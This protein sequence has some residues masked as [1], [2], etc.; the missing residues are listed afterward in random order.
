MDRRPDADPRLGLVAGP[1]GCSSSGRTSPG[2]GHVLDRDDDLEL[3]RLAARRRRR[4]SPSRPGPTPPRKRA[5]VSSG[6][7]VALR[8]IRCGGVGALARRRRGARAAPGVSARCAPRFEPAIA[9]TSSTIT[10]ST[11]RRTSRAWLVSIRYSDSGV[12]IRM[13]GGRRARFAALLGGRVA[14]AA[15]DRDVRGRLAEAGGREGDPGE[16]RPEVAL[17]VVGQGL[18]RGDVQ[19]ADA[20]RVRL[21]GRRAG[22][23]TRPA[24]RGVQRNAA[25]VLPL[26][27]GAWI[28]VWWPLA[29]AA[30]PSAWACVG[31]AN[32]LSNQARTAGENGR[33]RI[34]G[35][36]GGRRSSRAG[37][38][39]VATG[40][41]SIGVRG[42]FR[43]PVR[44]HAGGPGRRGR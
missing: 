8:P 1:P 12:V 4:S 2:F 16:R 31:A 11:P 15:G 20:A 17:D 18:E 40:V 25:R 39:T 14:G 41:G 28:S 7:C 3:E 19:D 36:I 9:W 34:A 26:P 10:C 21:R 27:V 38:I 43:P 29:I 24:G 33:Q 30:Q 32:E 44:N 6:R 5:I 13:S 22:R 23:A 35:R 37:A 42:P